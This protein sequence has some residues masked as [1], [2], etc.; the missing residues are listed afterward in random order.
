M[1]P[2]TQHRAPNA[3]EETQPRRQAA[4][5]STAP[6]FDYEKTSFLLS[7]IVLFCIERAGAQPAAA[8]PGLPG[9]TGL[10][11]VERS[12]RQQSGQVCFADALRSYKLA[13]QVTPGIRASRS[14]AASCTSGQGQS[15]EA[16]PYYRQFLATPLH[17]TNRPSAESR[18][19]KAS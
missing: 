16:I 2:R 6:S 12:L 9:P 4:P 13:Y 1:L 10:Q 7:L 14:I 8:I 18:L 5:T 15:A 17:Q 3:T 19:R 11:A